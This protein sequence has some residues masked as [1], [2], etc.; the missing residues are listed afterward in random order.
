M[1]NIDLS[2]IIPVYN[3]MPLLERTFNSIFAQ[4]THYTYE[5]ILVDDGGKD[6]SVDYIKSRTEPNIVLIQ[7]QNAGPARARNNGLEHA[8]GRYCAYL[9]ADDFWEDTFIEKTVSFL[10]EHPDCVAASVG[11]RHL[12]VSGEGIAPK[13]IGD[14]S[15]PVILTDFFNI[16]GQYMHVCT[17]SVTIRTEVMKTIGG[18]RE[19]LRIAEDLE[20]WALVSTYG[21]WAFIPEVLFTSDGIDLIK[22]NATW[23]RKMQPRWNNAPSV[24]DWQKRLV[25]RLG[26]NLPFGFLKARGKIASMFAYSHIM[27]NREKL[28]RQEVIT[29]GEYFTKN[30]ANKILIAASKLSLTWWLLCKC[31]QIK[32]SRRFK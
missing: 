1:T 11:Q 14:Y 9:D 27:S 30:N 19:D 26:I 15:T 5:V 24:E 6:N 18:Q 32:E 7:Q 28:A 2:V 17:G 31:L 13:C 8:N 4:K 10:D 3:A 12:T 29:Y 25:A 21:N 20:F 22:D 23:M 16:W